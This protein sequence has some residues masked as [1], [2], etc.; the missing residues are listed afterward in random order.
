MIKNYFKIAWRNLINNRLY[1][2][3]NCVGLSVG[4]AVGIL[5][6]LWVQDELSFDRFH[7]N[8]ARIYKLENQVGTGSSQQIWT[9]TVAPIAGFA[10]RELPEVEDAA[11]LA[12]N[13]SYTLFRY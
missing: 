2:L 11:R 7:T 1:S 8:A 6:L 12:Y 10:K 9:S 3:I 5:I 13:S 4:L